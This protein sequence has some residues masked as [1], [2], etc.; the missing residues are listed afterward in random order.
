MKIA[1]YFGVLLHGKMANENGLVSFAGSE[2]IPII[3]IIKFEKN[4]FIQ[5][6]HVYHSIWQPKIG[7][8]LKVVAEPNNIADKYIVCVQKTKLLKDMFQKGK[9]GRFAKT[10]FF[11]RAYKFSSCV[12]VVNG[13]RVNFGDSKGVQVPCMVII[14]RQPKFM[15][16]LKE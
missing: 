16:I 5:G 12:A 4:S 9:T 7:E 15:S 1:L 3:N 8:E 10:T 13:N 11:L 2:E 6:H 14:F